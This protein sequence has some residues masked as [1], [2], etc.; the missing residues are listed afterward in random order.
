MINS[1]VFSSIEKTLFELKDW[2]LNE[3]SKNHQFKFLILNE[4]LF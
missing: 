2:F 3:E 4:Y 1:T